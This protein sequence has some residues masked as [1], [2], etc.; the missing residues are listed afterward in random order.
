MG[1]W[2]VKNSVPSDEPARGTFR[3][4]CDETIYVFN[5]LG[6]QMDSPAISRRESLNL[7]DDAE[8]SSMAT[9]QE[10]RHY[11]NLQADLL[12]LWSSRGCLRDRKI[13]WKF[14]KSEQNAKHQPKVA[15]QDEVLVSNETIKAHWKGQQKGEPEN[16]KTDRK[17]HRSFQILGGLPRRTC[18]Y[19]S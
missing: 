13:S 1:T 14:R 3:I 4:I 15:I 17:P 7:F 11:N 10:W 6:K 12:C 19:V 18:D 5:A 8:L 2:N 16:R 9:I